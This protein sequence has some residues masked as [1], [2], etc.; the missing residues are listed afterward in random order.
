MIET[1]TRIIIALLLAVIASGTTFFHFV[2]G[3]SWL[4]SYFFTVVTLSTVGYGNLVPVTPI[5]MIGT[6]VLIMIGLGIFAAA[7]QQFGSFAVRHRENK[8]RLH[9]DMIRRQEE[10]ARR[11]KVKKR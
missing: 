7:I 5:G 3:W 9:E 1:R 6:T 8:V 10:A 2:E 11:I 4:D